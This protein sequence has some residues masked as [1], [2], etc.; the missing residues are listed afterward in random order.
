MKS[1]F[2]FCLAALTV[3]LSLPLGYA[4]ETARPVK[5]KA[6]SQ[7][8]QDAFLSK[9]TSASMLGSFRAFSSLLYAADSV[10]IHTESPEIIS[11]QLTSCMP[12]FYKPTRRELFDAIAVQTQSAWRYDSGKSCWVFAKHKKPR[13]YYSIDSAKGW[14]RN[15]RGLYVGYHPA[16][17]PV[18][19]DIYIMGSYSSDKPED[20]NALYK[21]VRDSFAVM[22]AKN[23]KQDT[24]SSDMK[25]ITVNT[26]QALF[27]EIT[28]PDKMIWRQWVIVEAGKAFV[29]VSAIKSEHDDQIYPD[30]QKMLGSFTIAK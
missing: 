11:A 14:T 20:A 27:F 15:D 1:M 4:A 5:V 8:E 17:A 13:M 21:K 3:M 7:S 30:V 22:F 23:F 12:D 29:I 16:I 26:C 19:M 2:S 6:L 18:G 9:R 24:A 28:T 25:E 10:V